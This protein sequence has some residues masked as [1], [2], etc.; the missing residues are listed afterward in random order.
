MITSVNNINVHGLSL[1]EVSALLVGHKNISLSFKHPE[2]IARRPSIVEDSVA[3]LNMIGTWGSSLISKATSPSITTL[4][5]ENELAVGD[6]LERKFVK[7]SEEIRTYEDY[8]FESL[9]EGLQL[10]SVSDMHT[11]L[12][13]LRLN[14]VS[15]SSRIEEV[16][17]FEW[18]INDLD[19]SKY[20]R[21][22]EGANRFHYQPCY[23]DIGYQMCLKCIKKRK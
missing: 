9:F 20:F 22:V 7:H 6:K 19:N 13:R 16:M 21:Q 8:N 1:K 5:T 11:S 15:V 23:P 2:V 18:W 14:E 10:Y 12:I 3:A 17:T 4:T